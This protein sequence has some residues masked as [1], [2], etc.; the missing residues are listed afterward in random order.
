VTRSKGEYQLSYIIMKLDPF[1][2]YLVPIY[3]K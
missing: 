2:A 1:G 3:I